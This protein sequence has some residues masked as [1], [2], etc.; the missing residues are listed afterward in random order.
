VSTDA[1]NLFQ[2]VMQL[3]EGERFKLVSRLMDAVPDVPEE[4][5]FLSMDDPNLREELDRRFA[6]PEGAISWEELRDRNA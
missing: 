1:D 4:L 5:G 6:T 2:A 3:P